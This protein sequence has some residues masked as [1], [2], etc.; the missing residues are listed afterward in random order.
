MVSV[1]KRH[2]NKISLPSKSSTNMI[3]TLATIVK[4]AQMAPMI[5]ILSGGNGKPSK[6][7]KFGQKSG[8]C[9]ILRYTITEMR[10]EVTNDNSE[11]QN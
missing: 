8:I 4:T 9:Y 7:T 1:H 2:H 10:T 5:V 3:Y 6:Y 11:L